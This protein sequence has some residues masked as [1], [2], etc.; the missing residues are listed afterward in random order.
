MKRYS[1]TSSGF[2]GEVIFEFD[3][4]QLLLRFDATAAQLSDGQHIFLLKNLPVELFAIKA[5]V[6]KSPTARL[7]EIVVT[8]NFNMFWIKY[9][10]KIRSSKK[11]AE[12]IWNRLSEI[13]REKAYKYIQKYEMSL[14]PGTAKKYAETYLG[15]E[16]WN[17]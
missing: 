2:E 6:E 16:L 1:L 5:F 8:V 9:N 3:D 10:E 7:E 12:R 17:N 13:D 15:A 14:L 11:K 4:N